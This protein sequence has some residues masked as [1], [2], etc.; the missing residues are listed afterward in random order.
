MPATDKIKKIKK[1]QECE[2]VQ[3]F[4]FVFH[5]SALEMFLLSS[6]AARKI[7][8]RYLRNR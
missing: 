3:H 6:N 7:F 4:Y 1:I 2:I 5:E 8:L